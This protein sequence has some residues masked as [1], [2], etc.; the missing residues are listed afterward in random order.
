MMAIEASTDERKIYTALQTII[1]AM[2]EFDQDTRERM[3]RTVSTFFGIAPQFQPQPQELMPSARKHTVPAFS[4]REDL[5]PKDFLV[6]KKPKTDVERVACLAF[7]LTHYRSTAHFKTID[8]SKLNTE[9]AQLK[10][11]NA[12]NSL[13]NAVKSGFLVPSVS[14][15]KQLSAAGEK[16]V[17]HLPDRTMVRKVMSELSPRRK[18]RNVAKDP[19]LLSK[20]QGTLRNE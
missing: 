16:F 18:K 11:T 14:G 1:D 15:A 8:L 3:L 19:N 9:A 5:S 4:N 17:D 13:N 6:Q 12:S 10:F 20:S 7:Y 2:L